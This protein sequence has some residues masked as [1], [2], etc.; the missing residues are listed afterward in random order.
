MKR[1]T[2]SFLISAVVLGLAP[3]CGTDLPAESSPPGAELR[4]AGP[5]DLAV[6]WRPVE[7]S[8]S[9]AVFG[10]ELT[11]ENRGSSALGATGWHLYFSFVRRV[12]RD[13]EG[14]GAIVQDLA[15][16]GIRITR[17]DAA[18]SGDYWVLEPVAG[19]APLGAG[20]RRVL[21]IVAENWAILKTDA[22]AGFHVAF[23]GSAGGTARAVAATVAID[24]ADPRQTTRFSGDVMPVETAALR[25]AENPARQPLELADQLL[26]APRVA[27]RHPGEVRLGSALVIEHTRALAGEAAYLAAA[28]DDVLGGSCGRRDALASHRGDAAIQLVLDPGLD[29]DRDG[30]PDAEAYVLDAADGR[31][32]IRR[33]TRRRGLRPRRGR[34]PDRDPRQRPARC[35]LRHPDP[36]P[37]RAQGRLPR[38]GGPR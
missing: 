20:Q 2:T 22:P 3:G 7:H 17:A 14:D 18:A 12:L 16:Q 5:T 34:R 32:V 21:H 4:A 36:A 13:G 19:F 23:D 33:S 6:A 9:G 24:A 29:V 30:R 37:A 11:L 31:I 35:V 8:A 26:P 27:V 28:L 25:H 38:R 1:S 10:S 15:G